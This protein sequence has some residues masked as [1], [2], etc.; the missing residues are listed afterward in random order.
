MTSDRPIDG[1]QV[2]LGSLLVTEVALDLHGT[3]L[4][5][6]AQP[7]AP[8]AAIL[9][10]NRG[11]RIGDRYAYHCRLW[12]DRGLSPA[13]RGN[14]RDERLLGVFLHFSRVESRNSLQ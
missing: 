13:L 5:G 7:G 4:R 10:I 3:R 8:L 2:E 1:T 9:Q 12:A 14:S 6:I 11:W